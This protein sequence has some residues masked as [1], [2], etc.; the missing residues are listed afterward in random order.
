M[1]DPLNQITTYTYNSRGLAET[2]TD[3][4]G[5]VVTSEQLTGFV[6]EAINAGLSYI[7]GKISLRVQYGYN[8]ERLVTFNADPSLRRWE[9]ATN[10][11]DLKA[12]YFFRRLLSFYADVYN[13]TGNNQRERFGSGKVRFL[14][15]RHDPQFH[16]GMEGRF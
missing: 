13:L 9:L 15:D 14:Q 10:R 16:F 12:K 5:N 8:A 4:L 6:P 1:K 3:P 7:K 11:V 2:R